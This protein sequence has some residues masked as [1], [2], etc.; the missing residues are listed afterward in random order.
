MNAPDDDQPSEARIRV[1]KALDKMAVAQKSL[2]AFVPQ[3]ALH[4]DREERRLAVPTRLRDWRTV[5]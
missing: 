4:N 2:A 3:Y 5:R 1:A